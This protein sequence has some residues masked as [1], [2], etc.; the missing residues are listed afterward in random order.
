MELV[1]DS[2]INGTV[3]TVDDVDSAIGQVS[4]TLAVVGAQSSQYGHYGTARGADTLFP[5]IG[6]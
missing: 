5:T 1:R 4:T 2:A 6:K 3:S